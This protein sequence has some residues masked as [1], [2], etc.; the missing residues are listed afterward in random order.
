MDEG[1]SPFPLVQLK[2]MVVRNL[3]RTITISTQ[4]WCVSHCGA[5]AAQPV[6]SWTKRTTKLRRQ[7]TPR[8]GAH[9]TY[10]SMWSACKRGGACIPGQIWGW[11][12]GR[13]TDERSIAPCRT[14]AVRYACVCA[15]DAKGNR[16]PA[17]S[18]EA[19]GLCWLPLVGRQSRNYGVPY[20]QDAK[21]VHWYVRSIFIHFIP[22]GTEYTDTVGSI[23][24]RASIGKPRG[25]I[26]KANYYY[27]YD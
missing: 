11:G 19:W 9:K 22:V 6:C 27:F 3:E 7:R 4:R 10:A 23:Y 26:A 8:N 25:M 2:L 17:H 16:T 1:K 12:P 14:R 20:V 13:E 15:G 18:E 24:Y 5:L 21:T